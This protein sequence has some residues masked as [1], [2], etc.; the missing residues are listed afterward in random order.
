MK[1]T[2]SNNNKTN[3]EPLV[4]HEGVITKISGDNVTVSLKGNINC[5]GCKAKSACGVS[6]TN[7]KEIEVYQT[8]MSLNLNEPVEVLLNRNLGLKAVFL[9]YVLPFI[10]MMVVLITASYFTTEWIA[11]LFALVILI[12]YFLVVLLFKHKLKKTFQ[13]SI[14]KLS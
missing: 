5:E 7:N 10:I 14:L 3:N 1:N 2:I 11:G 9:A 13:L 12:P 4:R 8:S 6:E